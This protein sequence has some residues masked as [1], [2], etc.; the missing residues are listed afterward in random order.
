MSTPP[1]LLPGSPQALPD[2]P[3]CG[4]P[5]DLHDNHCGW[6]TLG[7]LTAG[8]A[9]ADRRSAAAAQLSAARRR[10]RLTAALRVLDGYESA[11]RPV[12][13]TELVAD[14]APDDLDAAETAARPSGGTEYAD[15]GWPPAGT[16]AEGGPSFVRVLALDAEGLAE[17]RVAE[18]PGNGPQV[19][20]I[21]RTGW[22]RLLPGL[23]RDSARTRFTLAGGG[24]VDAAPPA[25]AHGRLP[26]WCTA[27]G[28]DQAVVLLDRCA[29][30]P[31]VSRIRSALGRQCRP[32]ATLHA[33]M[34]PTPTAQVITGMLRS[35]PFP[36]QVAL[37]V[38]EREPVT[39]GFV[40]SSVSLFPAGTRPG[41]TRTGRVRVRTPA[42]GNP[43]GRVSVTIAVVA[44]AGPRPQDWRLLHAV[45]ADL[46]EDAEVDI[47]ITP[48]AV[49]EILIGIEGQPAPTTVRTAWPDLLSRMA[50][51]RRELPL[52]LV[53]L[54]E[55]GGEESDERVRAATR[56]I[57]L[58]AASRPLG[59][60]R[61]RTVPYWEHRRDPGS[62][63]LEPTHT[64]WPFLPP[65]QVL[66]D[67][68]DL[69]GHN[70]PVR[71]E[72]AAALEEPLAELAA[73][74]G[75]TDGDRCLLVVATRPPHL[76]PDDELR[77]VSRRC[78]RDRDWRD[79]LTASAEWLGRTAVLVPATQWGNSFDARQ[80]TKY[81]DDLWRTSQEHGWHVLVADGADV[82]EKAA[83]LTAPEAATARPVPFPF[84]V[85]AAPAPA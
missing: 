13:L 47:E 64:V 29:A 44:L 21:H 51:A 27:A 8:P 24:A 61:V 62:G 1:P 2:C 59:G 65:A 19:K 38:A 18:G 40:T 79:G 75:W 57:E 25:P 84:S 34:S 23:P 68:T 33:A 10:G 63:H 3:V 20:E 41:P 83:A 45:E 15:E 6:P 35:A 43:S 69:Y 82:L 39:Q 58:M 76:G 17:L 54:L 56:I 46:P 60:L 48:A 26:E 78:P 16:P 36:H 71:N 31:G 5:A 32:A 73:L 49:D 37:A 14:A 53:I 9:T 11:D 55:L 50:R 28:D 66:E 81:S 7:P 12:W 4:A 85:P 67:M 30:W 80:A 42:S 70:E 72:F 22:D 74:D 52:D 77:S